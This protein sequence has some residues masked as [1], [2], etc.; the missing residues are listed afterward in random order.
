MNLRYLFK[1]TNNIFS[2]SIAVEIKF[3]D[4]Q[5]EFTSTGCV[6][7]LACLVESLSL[8]SALSLSLKQNSEKLSTQVVK[9]NK[10]S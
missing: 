9:S 3:V 4:L 6:S 10:Y 7:L 5:V 2:W 8:L 1:C